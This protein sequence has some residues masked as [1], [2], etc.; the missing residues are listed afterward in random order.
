MAIRIVET[1]YGTVEGVVQN[2]CTHSVFKGIPFAKPPVGERRMAAPEAPD[3]WDGIRKCDTFAPAPV[4]GFR[5]GERVIETSEDCLYLNVFTPAENVDEK[6][7]V[8]VWIFGGGFQG[9]SASNPEFDGKA[10]NDHGVILVTINYRCGALGFFANSKIGSLNLGLLD[11]QAALKWVQENIRAFGGDPENVT[12]FGQSAGGMSC[13]MQIA[14]PLAKGLFRKAIVESGGGLNEADPI[15]ST[16]EFRKMCDSCLEYLGWSEE[17][18]MTRDAAEVISEMNRAARETVGKFQVGYFQ[19]FI[20]GCTIVDIPGKLIKEGKVNDVQVMVGT[21]AGDSWMFSSSVKDELAGN[22]NYFRGCA[23]TSQMAWAKTQIE[24]G[25]DTI[26]TFYMDRVQPPRKPMGNGGMGHGLPPFGAQTPHSSEIPYVF[27]TLSVKEQGLAEPFTDYDREL[28]SVMTGY[29][30]N[31]AKN[32][33]PN[34]EGLPT[35]PKAEGD[36]PL[37]M[38]FGDNGYG[39]ENIITSDDEMRIVRYTM[40]HPGLLTDVTGLEDTEI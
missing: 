28:S 6:L 39:A 1:K 5:P 35:W 25:R 20:D 23:I 37:S 19:P 2:G 17:D 10:I 27:G 8:M 24:E 26:Y 7:P 36:E 40:L 30:T 14:S 34:G 31:F 38:H 11:Q 21:V 29:W 4:Q 33:D 13:R 22:I 12:I 9:G 18:I 32:G 3:G 15:K 16:E